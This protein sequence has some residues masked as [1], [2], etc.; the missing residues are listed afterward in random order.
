[1]AEILKDVFEDEKGNQ[2]YLANNTETTFD[3]NGTPLNNG[4]DLSE[5]SVNFTVS[6]SRKALTAK[7]RFKALMGD[8]AKWLTDLGPAAFY[9]VADDFTTTAENYL[10]TARKGKQLKDEVDNLNQNLNG[11]QFSTVNGVPSYK[12]GADAAWVPLGSALFGEITLPSSPNVAVSYEV[13]FRPSKL[14]V[15][16]N[17][18]TFSSSV[19]WRYEESRGFTEEYSYNS[20][21][22]V[23]YNK[24]RSIA[25][26]DTGFTITIT[27]QLHRGA[28]ARYFALR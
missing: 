9:K 24:N 13:G 14:C 11:Y 6:S 26:T 10:F 4:G 21:D 20:Y 16:T 28:P 23:A 2:H 22:G 15:M 19:V 3:Q 8:I 5:A 17:S 1:M 27:G 25:I 12:A 18:D 7:A